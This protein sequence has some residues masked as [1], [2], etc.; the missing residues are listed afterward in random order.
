MTMAEN[1]SFDC[2]VDLLVAGAGAAGMTAALVGAIEG[3]EVVICEKSDKVGGITSTSAGTVWI[4]GSTQSKQAG[5]P[6]S[7]EAASVYLASVIGAADG[8]TADGEAERRAFLESGQQRAGCGRGRNPTLSIW[9]PV[10]ACEDDMGP[11]EG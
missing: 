3:L 5:V 4:P 1:C 10:F 6:D 11:S 9:P 8:G 2:T 7:I